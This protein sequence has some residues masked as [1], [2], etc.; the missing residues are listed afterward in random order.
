MPRLQHVDASFLAGECDPAIV[1]RLDDV[2]RANAASKIRNMYVRSAGGV[3]VRPGMRSI[4]QL[5]S[6]PVVLSSGTVRI[7]NQLGVW[8]DV[9]SSLGLRQAFIPDQRTGRTLPNLGL[10]EVDFGEDVAAGT[11]VTLRLRLDE[12]AEQASPQLYWYEEASS[13]TDDQMDT[14]PVGRFRWAGGPFQVR[15]KSYTDFTHTLVN[16]ARKVRIWARPW[17]VPA[18]GRP[19]APVA[20]EVALQISGWSAS[21]EDASGSVGNT[22]AVRLLDVTWYPDIAALL[23]LH[24]AHATVVY[25]ESGANEP[26]LNPFGF[27]QETGFSNEEVRTMRA[28]KTPGGA[29]LYSPEWNKPLHELKLIQPGG[30]TLRLVL[31]PNPDIYTAG[32]AH[33]GWEASNPPAAFLA[34]QGRI[35]AAGT[36]TKPNGIWLSAVLNPPAQPTRG[37]FRPPTIS[38][39]RPLLASDAFMVEEAGRPLN[40]FVDIHGGLLTVFFGT[41]GISFLDRPFIDARNFGFRENSERGILA[42]VPPVEIGT[43][44][45]AFV[46][47]SGRSVWLMTYANERQGYVMSE[48]SQVAPH[49]LDRPED[50]VYFDRLPDGGN[51]VLIVNGDAVRS[52]ACCSVQPEG[53]W[54][55]WSRWE[56]GGK[57]EGESEGYDRLLDLEVAGGDLWAVT[58]RDERLFLERF[59]PDLELDFCHVSTDGTHPY[60]ERYK[61]WSAVAVMADGSRTRL[62]MSFPEQRDLDEIAEW[63][64]RIAQLQADPEG[65]YA[66]EIEELEDQVAEVEAKIEEEVD[67]LK[68]TT[69]DVRTG[70]AHLVKDDR[71]GLG[72]LPGALSEVVEWHVGQPFKWELETMPFVKRTGEG[73]AFQSPT[74]TQE[75]FQ[76]WEA[77]DARDTNL[78]LL[79]PAFYTLNGEL[80]EPTPRIFD[81]PPVGFIRQGRT[82]HLNIFGWHEQNTIRMEGVG[83]LTIS[84]ISRTVVS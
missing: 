41:H 45:L 42:G 18:T 29:L 57:R 82:R 5:R 75:C 49:L 83:G 50:C 23:V 36:R 72:A 37:D 2:V 74:K 39:T 28:S 44:R 24:G 14:P 1:A 68:F 10:V 7:R 27:N 38:Q 84:S 30:R 26:T 8:A 51:A 70:L 47:A 60:A 3:R 73:S 78:G 22:A 25:N 48:L 20:S 15:S 71:P 79:Q 34:H 12:H 77:P 21:R 43:G 46:E 56:T 65:G 63:K 53:E 32:T 55:A 35:I 59:D 19:E 64:S 17:P 58:E 62:A 40:R 16:E 11:A 66:A 4:L 67:A 13:N 6:R 33:G 81:T 54:H 31:R 61:S 52:I 69:S 80:L 9:T 76:N